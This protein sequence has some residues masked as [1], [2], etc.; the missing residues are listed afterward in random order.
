[1]RR[2]A[3]AVAGL[4]AGA[5]QAVCP[6]PPADGTLLAA[7]EVSLAWRA[8]PAHI[9]Q[10]Q[11]FALLLTLCPAGAELAAV[12]ATM[13]AHRHGMNYR[14]S[15]QPLGDGRWRAEGLLWHMSGR[16]EL[17]LEVTYSGRVHT[18]RHDVLLP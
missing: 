11:P 17:R 14:P 1:M 2:W 7:G 5:A 3:I 6:P 16:W 8:E 4:L 12:D 13:P 9:V 10:G 15:L 18:L